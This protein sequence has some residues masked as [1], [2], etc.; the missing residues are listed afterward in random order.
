MIAGA[1]SLRADPAELAALQPGATT[2]RIAADARGEPERFTYAALPAGDQH[3]LLELSERLDAERAYTRRT[4]FD[5]VQTTVALALVTALLSYLL[6]SW[7]VGRPVRALV[8]KARRMAKRDFG[9][10][11]HLT[12]GDELAELAREMNATSDALVAAEVRVAG[13]TAARI[14][15][16]EQLRHADRLT[17]VGK[18]ASGVARELGTPL[19]VVTAR[20]EMIAAGDITAEESRDYAGIIVDSARKMTRIIRQLLEFAR[21]RDPRKEQGDVA[22]VA[23]HALELLRPLAERQ[24][25]SLRLDDTGGPFCTNLDAGQIEQ[26]VTNLVVN[27]VQASPEG[28]EVDVR[29]TRERAG[30]PT[31]PGDGEA[32]WIAV[33]VRDRGQGIAPEHLSHVFEPFFTTKDVG[34]GTGLGL[35]VAYGIA[36]DHGGWIDVASKPR[37]GSTFAL[38]LPVET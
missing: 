2:T 33:R 8:E 28:G 36:S 14:A 7:L 21:R 35:S 6:G 9:G 3:G 20:A 4:I 30:P 26:T 32:E 1:G 16:M 5:T 38:F 12:S 11:V 22:A 24:R 25:I 27:A 17:T 19:N 18:L 31:D 29:V 34:S 37:H 15:A 23:R 13:E 10:A